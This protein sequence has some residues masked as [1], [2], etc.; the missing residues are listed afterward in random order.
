[1]LSNRVPNTQGQQGNGP[2]N[3]LLGKTQRDFGNFAK[4][5][6]KQGILCGQVVNALILKIKDIVTFAAKVSNFS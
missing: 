3:S 1:M 4:R 5:E 2:N 6:G